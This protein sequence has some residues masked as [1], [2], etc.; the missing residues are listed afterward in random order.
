MM[1]SGKSC[2]MGWAAAG[3]LAMLIAATLLSAQE[4]KEKITVDD[5]DR[6][7]MLRLPKGYDAQRHYPVV[8]LL[9][10]MNQ[11]A[12]DMERLTQFDQVADKDGIISVY[13]IA[14]NGRWNIGV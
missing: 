6:T 10:G 8:M 9:H 12:D 13:P 14:M 2:G 1:K 7:F 4:T 5:V 3:C 11:D